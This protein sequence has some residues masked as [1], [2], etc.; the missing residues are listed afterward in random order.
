MVPHG[1]ECRCG[2]GNLLARVVAEGLEIKCRKCKGIVLIAHEEL[3][4]MYQKLEFRPSPFAPPPPR[5]D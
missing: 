4:A 2:C 1:D 3:V 5:R